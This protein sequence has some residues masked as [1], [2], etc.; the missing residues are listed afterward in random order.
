M[1]A[2]GRI[3][4]LILRNSDAEGAKHLS[5]EHP[6][7]SGSDC[8]RDLCRIDSDSIDGWRFLLHRLITDSLKPCELIRYLKQRVV[9][10]VIYLANH[11]RGAYTERLCVVRLAKPAYRAY[12]C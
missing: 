11:Q 8:Q 4:G 7:S 2:L 12:I 5:A 3:A 6:S 10:L 9:T 1:G